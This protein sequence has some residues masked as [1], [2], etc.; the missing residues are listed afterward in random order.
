MCGELELSTF[1]YELASAR[2]R[3]FLFFSFSIS[4]VSSSGREVMNYGSGRVAKDKEKSD[5]P[6]AC[7]VV[8]LGR[9]V[10]DY[11]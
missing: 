2:M 5:L 8:S 7:V 9:I 4:P 11:K 10:C 3:N 1:L 6:R